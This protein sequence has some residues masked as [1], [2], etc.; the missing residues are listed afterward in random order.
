MRLLNDARNHHD[1]KEIDMTM[2]TNNAITSHANYHP[3]DYTYLADKGYTDDEILAIW[4][5]DAELGKGPQTHENNP[6][7]QTN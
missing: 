2:T 7:F 1:A 5:R 6:F 3:A 4:T